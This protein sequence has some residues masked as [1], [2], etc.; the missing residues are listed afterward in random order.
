MNDPVYQEASE[1]LA[2]RMLKAADK[3]DDR[4]RYGARMVLSRDPTDYE[5]ARLR[6]LFEK[7]LVE[8]GV[9]MVKRT[10]YGKATSENEKR[11]LTAVASV[12]FNLDA[13]LTR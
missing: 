2:D 3:T 11:A 8:S 9:G 7:A 6:E 12:L 10:V 13:A 1:A 5:L 4:L